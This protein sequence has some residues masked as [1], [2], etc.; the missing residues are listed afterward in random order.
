MNGPVFLNS[1][2]NRIPTWEKRR[3]VR[4]S[5]SGQKR[6]RSGRM[7]R[8]REIRTGTGD[9]LSCEARSNTHWA[10]RFRAILLVG[11]GPPTDRGDAARVQWDRANRRVSGRGRG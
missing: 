2:F 3:K 5:V 4:L 8:R 6:M 10:E 7:R 9:E 1:D 11:G